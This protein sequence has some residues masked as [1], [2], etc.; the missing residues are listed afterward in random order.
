MRLLNNIL[1]EINAALEANLNGLDEYGNIGSL[2][3]FWTE[4]YLHVQDAK[5]YPVVNSGDGDGQMVSFDDSY[6]MQIYHRVIDVENGSNPDSGY[7]RNV[8][9][10]KVYKMRLVGV[11]TINK[12]PE[13]TW[14]TN[15][16]IMSLVSSALPVDLT[17]ELSELND[18]QPNKMDVIASE[19]AGHDYEKLKFN[20]I[21]FWIEYS[22][23]Q[24]ADCGDVTNEPF[25]SLSD[26]V[27]T[28]GNDYVY[29]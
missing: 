1:S 22:I 4:A 13:R 3:Q 6:A 27:A 14:E 2:T 18:E 26:V 29:T 5:T 9:R 28:V 19:F 7:G 24:R 15:T 8:R 17:Y 16:D 20:L 25:I 11:G 23:T 12:F 10:T 21:A